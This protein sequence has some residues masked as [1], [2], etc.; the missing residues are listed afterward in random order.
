MDIDNYS[1]EEAARFLGLRKKGLRKRNRKDKLWSILG[2]LV[3]PIMILFSYLKYRNGA[4][5]FERFVVS[6]IL[7]SF[8][9]IVCIFI[10]SG[11]FRK[12]RYR[13]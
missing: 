8:L 6:A 11:A 4:E 12:N 1:E 2:I 10:A 9:T 7:L 5:S 3:F 13:G